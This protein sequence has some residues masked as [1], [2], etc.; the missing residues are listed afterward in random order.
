MVE[1][2]RVPNAG[3][4]TKS[5]WWQK[6][7]FLIKYHWMRQSAH[8]SRFKWSEGQ[9]IGCHPSQSHETIHFAHGGTRFSGD[10]LY[11]TD[12]VKCPTCT[13]IRTLTFQP[14]CALL[15]QLN[16]FYCFRYYFAMP[17]WSN[18][19]TPARWLFIDTYRMASNVKWVMRETTAKCL[20]RTS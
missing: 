20:S 13:G 10:F 12:V 7:Q 6:M 5:G 3:Q 11:C 4:L 2:G 8:G 16:L 19:N 15:P 18:F 17:L 9:I 14:C 1:K